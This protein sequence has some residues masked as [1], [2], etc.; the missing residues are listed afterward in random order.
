VFVLLGLVSS[1]IAIPFVGV[2]ASPQGWSGAILPYAAVVASEQ[3]LELLLEYLR[4]LQAY[5]K[6]L[7]SPS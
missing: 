6:E 3:P 7:M 5:G 1:P 4:K 2:R